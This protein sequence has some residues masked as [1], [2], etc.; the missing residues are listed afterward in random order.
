LDNSLDRL[1]PQHQDYISLSTDTGDEETNQ[2]SNLDLA[3]VYID[4]ED[5]EAAIELLD[6]VVKLGT[7]EQKDEATMLL[8][9]IAS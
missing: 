7:P 2:A 1:G 6:E 5:T 3:Q 8:A 9:S 4:M